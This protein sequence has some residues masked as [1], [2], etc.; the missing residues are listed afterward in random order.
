MA[1][2]RMIRQSPFPA[3]LEPPAPVLAEV[4]HYPDSDGRFLPENPLQASAI[5]NLRAALTHHFNEVPRVVLRGGMFMYYE[6]GNPKKNIAP[7]IFVVLDHDLGKRRV[8]KIW[9]EGKPPD[10]ALEV[11]SPSTYTHNEE[12]KVVLYARLG[13]GEYFRFQPDPEKQEPRLVG[14]RLHRGEYRDVE[15]EPGG[16]LLSVSLGVEM[17]VEGENVRVRDPVTG[18]EYPWMDEIPRNTKA[19]ALRLKAEVEAR[20]L[21]DARAEAEAARAETEAEARRRSEAR[22]EAEAARAEAEAAR[23]EAEAARA[24]AEAEVRRRLE[25]QAEADKTRIAELESRLRQA[26]H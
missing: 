10:F 23:A 9:E 4:I 24:E 26:G 18:T 16:G 19:A 21:A 2:D 14:H 13:I 25:A 1:H 22:A 11:L 15:A 7:D 17:R 3:V 5:V 8:Y 6:E 12:E 20:R